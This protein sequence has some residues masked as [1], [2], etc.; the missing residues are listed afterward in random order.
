M[1]S[2]NTDPI[3]SRIGNVSGVIVGTVANTNSDG[4]GVIGNSLALAFTAD[5]TNGSFVQ[6][7]R[8]SPGATAAATATNA[9]VIRVFITSGSTAAATTTSSSTT[10]LWQE[11]AAPAQTADQTTTATNFI[12]VPL[13]FAL[14]AAYGI[15]VGSH[16]S[17]ATST[18]WTAVT[19]G[20]SY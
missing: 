18:V 7:I 20:G 1:S 4:S 9:T 2:S 15:L 3:Y 6:R 19:C 5:A 12:E 13:N 16:V 11:V 17:N 8:F 10:W 14:P